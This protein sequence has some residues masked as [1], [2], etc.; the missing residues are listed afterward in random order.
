MD[1]K[2]FKGLF[3]RKEKFG[4]EKTMFLFYSSMYINR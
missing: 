1:Y 2:S 4:N 3:F